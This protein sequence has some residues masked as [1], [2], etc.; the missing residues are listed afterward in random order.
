MLLYVDMSHYFDGEQENSFGPQLPERYWVRTA[1]D[2]LPDTIVYPRVD[3]VSIDEQTGIL[4][5]KTDSQLDASTSAWEDDSY[6]PRIGVLRIYQSNPD[7]SLIEGYIADVR[8]AKQGSISRAKITSE[9]GEDTRFK[10]RPYKY[11][12]LLGVIYEDEEGKSQYSSIPQL[13]E[14]TLAAA[15]FLAETMDRATADKKKKDEVKAANPKTDDTEISTSAIAKKPAIPAPRAP[16]PRS[17]QEEA[18][19]QGEAG[20]AVEA[21]DSLQ[22]SRRRRLLRWIIGGE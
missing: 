13:R 1:A 15:A 5:L 14:E 10:Y 4:F 19:Q 3:I 21:E 12:Q 22:P 8:T 18:S 16:E 11:A 17:G 6:S 20:Q 7:G 2:M 9:E